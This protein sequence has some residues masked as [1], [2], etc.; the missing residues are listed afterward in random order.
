MLNLPD[1]KTIEQENLTYN[2]EK[3]KN[4][5]FAV[6]NTNNKVL[7]VVGKKIISQAEFGTVNPADIESIEVRN[8]EDVSKYSSGKYDGVIV[9][10]LRKKRNQSRIK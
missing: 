4:E 1:G 6:G 3:R 7:Y 9:I 5:K 2:L 8:K 10:T